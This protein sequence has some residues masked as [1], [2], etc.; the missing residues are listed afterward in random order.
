MVT[1]RMPVPTC[2]QYAASLSAANTFT[3]WL[4]RGDATGELRPPELEGL[5]EMLMRADSMAGGSMPGDRG[6]GYSPLMDS[7][8]SS[9]SS[10]PSQVIS[11]PQ[12]WNDV[13]KSAWKLHVLYPVIAAPAPPRWVSNPQS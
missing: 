5:D 13:H 7:V 11:N 6:D 4:N 8:A 12:P 1:I 3:G 2:L 9:R 10:G